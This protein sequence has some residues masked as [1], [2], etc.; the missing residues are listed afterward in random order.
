[1]STAQSQIIDKAAFLA[2][3]LEAMEISALAGETFDIDAFQRASNSMRRLLESIGLERVSKD[4]T[5]TIEQLVAE[6][7][8]NKTDPA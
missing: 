7:R 8:A 6:M 2:A 3:Q 1:M 4:V 5:P